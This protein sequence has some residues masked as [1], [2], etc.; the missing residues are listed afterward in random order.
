[1]EGIALETA[2]NV[3]MLRGVMGKKYVCHI[4]IVLSI[5]RYEMSIITF[6]NALFYMHMHNVTGKE[7]VTA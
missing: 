7:Y 3:S 5:C 1:V 2:V 4:S 6:W